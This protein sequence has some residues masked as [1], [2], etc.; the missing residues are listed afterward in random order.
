MPQATAAD[1]ELLK[2]I[3]PVIRKFPIM[4]STPKGEAPRSGSD[5]VMLMVDNMNQI[6]VYRN[7]IEQRNR[8]RDNILQ[9]L[10][11]E[12]TDIYSVS[13]IRYFFSMKDSEYK[14]AVKKLDDEVKSLHLALNSLYDFSWS[15]Q[16]KLNSL[17]RERLRNIGDKLMDMSIR[18]KSSE[19]KLKEEGILLQL[20]IPG[21]V[22]SPAE[23]IEILIK[24]YMDIYAAYPDNSYTARNPITPAMLLRQGD[25][26]ERNLRRCAEYVQMTPKPSEAILNGENGSAPGDFAKAVYLG[27]TNLN[28]AAAA[29]AA[30]ASAA[31]AS[32]AA[33]NAAAAAAPAPKK[34]GLFWGGRR[35]KRRG[36]KRS[37]KTRGRRQTRSRR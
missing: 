37:K 25:D 9:I 18:L 26:L 12:L 5:C 24:L 1:N 15:S 27:L 28:K 10:G 16:E 21:D 34:K 3:N 4:T 17:D 29:S 22:R 23:L 36:A 8:Q 20:Q 30:A 31:A 11:I 6:T 7:Y 13:A 35:T 14:D 2:G 32:A 33:A 19:D